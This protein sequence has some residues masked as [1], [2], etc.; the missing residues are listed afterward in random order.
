M[1]RTAVVRWAYYVFLTMGAKTH[2]T[3]NRLDATF[4]ST[5]TIGW[6]VNQLRNGSGGTWNEVI[7]YI[8]ETK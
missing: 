6:T 2:K 5:P 4:N 3:A 7:D 1:I 8:E